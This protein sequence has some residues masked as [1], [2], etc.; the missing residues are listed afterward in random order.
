MHVQ[1]SAKAII[2]D[3]KATTA[4]TAA[5]YASVT[6]AAVHCLMRAPSQMPWCTY[7]RC[8]CDCERRARAAHGFSLKAEKIADVRAITTGTIPR[9]LPQRVNGS[10]G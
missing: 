8:R 3:A 6:V 7:H 9:Q 2:G 5:R 1:Q 10:A 4:P